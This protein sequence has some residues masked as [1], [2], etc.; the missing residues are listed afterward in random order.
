MH[1][2]LPHE[3]RERM[4]GFQVPIR[5][6][7]GLPNSAEVRVAIDARRTLRLTRGPWHEERNDGDDGNHCGGRDH[8]HQEPEPTS[9]DGAPSLVELPFLAIGI[10]RHPTPVHRGDG[11]ILVASSLLTSM[12]NRAPVARRRDSR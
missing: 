2:F 9:H 6:V 8:N 4:M 10:R 12:W 3:A 11:G 1:A 5:L 7:Q